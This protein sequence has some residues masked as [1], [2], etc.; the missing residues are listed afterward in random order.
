MDVERISSV[1]LLA[2]HMMANSLK[3]KSEFYADVYAAVSELIERREAAGE[4]KGLSD[5]GHKSED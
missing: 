3:E 5:D 2:L 4:W 1:Q